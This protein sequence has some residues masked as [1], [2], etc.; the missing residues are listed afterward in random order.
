LLQ[1]SSHELIVLDS[2]GRE[3]ESQLLPILNA[4]LNMRNYHVK[5]YLGKSPSDTPRYWLGFTA[6]VPPLGFNTYII[7]SAK[8]TGHILEYVCLQFGN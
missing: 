6:T 5:A 3:I 4:S 1:V 8:H 7:S 2:D